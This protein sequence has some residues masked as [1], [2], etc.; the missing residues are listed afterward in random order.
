MWPHRVAQ[1][2]CPSR[3]AQGPINCDNYKKLLGCLPASH[4]PCRTGLAWSLRMTRPK[5]PTARASSLP[6]FL[7]PRRG[8]LPQ[9]TSLQTGHLGIVFSQVRCSLPSR[10]Y[11][12][13]MAWRKEPETLARLPQGQALALPAGA[14]VE[15]RALSGS[16]PH[17]GVDSLSTF[18]RIICR[19]G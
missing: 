18:N 19:A 1:E 6:A 11:H 17:V 14:Q 12:G 3:V 10:H 2:L 9:L 5:P 8:D 13:S 7:A 4:G 15:N 16:P